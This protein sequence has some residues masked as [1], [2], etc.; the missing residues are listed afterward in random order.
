MKNKIMKLIK[1]NKGYSLV[2]LIVTIAILSLISTS[3]FVFFVTG[4][5]TYDRID[6]TLNLQ[7]QAQF[8]LA[9][10]QEKALDC[11]GSVSWIDS[12]LT[13]T[14]V[15][16]NGVNVT[17]QHSYQMDGA[18][19]DRIL[20]NN[21]PLGEYMTTESGVVPFEVVIKNDEDGNAVSMDVTLRLEEGGLKFETT[22]TIAFRN[23]ITNET[24]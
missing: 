13:L 3:I 1:S 15:D 10:I 14:Y 12:T 24:P 18:N 9:N 7:E 5:N 17:P 22:R 11:N 20:Y 19:N 8:T 4:A 6:D 23:I 21:Q 2:E 16:E